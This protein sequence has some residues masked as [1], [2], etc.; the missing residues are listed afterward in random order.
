[1]KRIRF[2]LMTMLLFVF[3]LAPGKGMAAAPEAAWKQEWDKHVAAAVK[4]G[5]LLVYT[6]LTSDTTR[7][8]AEAF[9][10]K[11]GI[12]VNYVIGRGPEV[13]E[14]LFT[15]RNAGLYLGDVIIQ[16]TNIQNLIFKPRGVLQ[17]MD[18]AL[19][20]PEVTDPRNWQH[21]RIP[22]VDKD[23]TSLAFLAN[24][25]R[26]L[27]RNTDLVKRDEIKS[28][29]DLLHPRWKGKIVLNDPTVTGPGSSWFTFIILKAFGSRE[30]GIEFARELARQEP[31]ISRDSRVQIEGLSRG[32]YSLAIA[33][34]TRL[35]TDFKKA[36]AHIEDVGVIE[37]STSSAG[38]GALSLLTRP[39]HPNASVVFANWVLTKEPQSIFVQGYGAPSARADVPPVGVDP[40][41]IPSPTDKVYLQ[42]E[43]F[44]LM[45]K[46]MIQLAKQI[47]APLLK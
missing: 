3:C 19:I 46:E 39:A 5:S 38:P 7:P 21:G 34:T 37:G 28:W 42:D 4:E 20:L 1:M 13:S 36:G 10:K 41:N 9:K 35:I 33:V 26:S 16:G 32:K 25:S 40:M 14:K 2:F 18:S 24:Y 43:E 27:T 17:V 22:W 23:H 6:P 44:D 30:K 47:F 29:K 15:E 45:N 8:L 11:F 12:E 31:L